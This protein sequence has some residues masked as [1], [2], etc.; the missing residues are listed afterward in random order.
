[1][2]NLMEIE[3]PDNIMDLEDMEDLDAK[4]DKSKKMTLAAFGP[5][6]KDKCGANYINRDERVDCVA[7]INHIE[8]GCYAALYVMESNEELEVFE[9]TDYYPNKTEAWQALES[10]AEI[11]PPVLFE[12][13][14][15]QQ[16]ITDKDATVER[17]EL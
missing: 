1:M 7:N 10:N 9:L 11:Y 4:D 17:L 5:W 14:V 15:G 2:E 13:W 8:P 12:E 6:I 3:N 16:Y